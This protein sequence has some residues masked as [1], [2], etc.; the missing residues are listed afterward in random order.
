MKY[1]TLLLV[2]LTSFTIQVAA[3]SAYQKK[4]YSIC[5]RYYTYFIDGYSHSLPL[6]DAVLFSV[7]PESM[8]AIAA[9]NALSWLSP[10]KV[11]KLIDQLSAEL[12]QA[13]KLMT[14]E[15]RAE[16]ARKDALAKKKE[17][18]LGCLQ[19]L[20]QDSL[21]VFATKGEFEKTTDYQT[22]IQQQAKQKFEYYCTYLFPKA[23]FNLQPIKY[24]ADKELY[25]FELEYTLSFQNKRHNNTLLVSV[26]IDVEAAQYLNQHRATIP[27]FDVVWG[28]NGNT[29]TPQSYKFTLNDNTYT[30]NTKVSDLILKTSDLDIDIPQLKNASFN[31]TAQQKTLNKNKQAYLAKINEWQ[32]VWRNNITTSPYYERLHYDYREQ[33]IKSD[34]LKPFQPTDEAADIY[35][36]YQTYVY[37]TAAEATNSNLL[38]QVKE[39][40]RETSNTAY[41]DAYLSENPELNDSLQVE[42][43]EYRCHYSSFQNFTR[44]FFDN[45][46]EESKR[47]CRE[48]AYAQ[49]GQYYDSRE[50]FDID[51]NK[52]DNV[53]KEKASL[54]AWL[55]QNV[56]E[57]EQLFLGKVAIYRGNYVP[58]S[59]S[60]S[61]LY[62]QGADNN[63]NY[64][65]IRRLSVLYKELKDYPPLQQRAADFIISHNKKMQKEYDKNGALFESKIDFVNAYFSPEY[66]K[67]L[68]LKK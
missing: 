43:I 48:N 42:Y 63:N 41:I 64:S 9:M 13:E 40:L 1:R 68:K 4:V 31:C 3:E 34:I 58:T 44:A 11:D 20:I 50:D 46:V 39:K 67:I 29:L 12:K 32:Q 28:L 49:Y 15:E 59:E 5:E 6:A 17:T 37:D 14:P 53:L 55:E 33:F 8:T 61:S 21:N 27:V 66:K 52:G 47:N 26:P 24:N 18:S 45:R 25:D 2:I 62:L 38:Q 16:K 19:L 23:S 57:I 60:V 54:Y 51:Y 36:F 22:R 7:D 10:Q 30:A 56:I 65:T 35:V